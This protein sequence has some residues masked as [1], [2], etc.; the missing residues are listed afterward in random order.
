MS[1]EKNLAVDESI[2]RLLRKRGALNYIL[3]ETGFDIGKCISAACSEEGEDAIK[4]IALSLG[5]S[6]RPV[7]QGFLF[8]AYRVYRTIKSPET[9]KKIRERLGGNLSWG[10]LVHNCTKAPEGN[11]E[12]AALFLDRQM[13]RIEEAL[14]DLERLG[15]S[16]EDLPEDVKEQVTGML[17]AIQYPIPAGQEEPN[18][19][20]SGPLRIA[21]IG[22]I[23]MS[24]LF[25]T[26]G[27]LVLDPETGK[28]ERL[29]DIKRCL[30]FAIDKA[31][32]RGCRVLLVAGDVADRENPT[33][34]EQGALQSELVRAADYMPVVVIPGNHDLSKN[35][36]DASA[37]EFLK[38]RPN[39]FVLEKPAVLYLEGKKITVRNLPLDENFKPSE[40][41]GQADC[42]KIFCL[43]FP[44]KAL[45]NGEAK[46][47]SIAELNVVA[48]SKLKFFLEMFRNNFDK[49]V[50]NILVSHITVAGA[51][52]ATNE[53]MLMFDPNVSPFDLAGFDYVAL[54]HIHIFQ[55]VFPHAFYSGSLDTIG[56]DE[57]G[58]KKGF[59]IGEFDPAQK[60]DE[61]I[62]LKMEFIE[63]PARQF[64]TLTPEFFDQPDWKEMLDPRTIYRVKGEVTK[65][66]YEALKPHLREFPVPLLNKLTVKREMRI[67]DKGMTD[68]LSE[69]DAIKRYFMQLGIPE[70]Q[71]SAYLQVHN[72]LLKDEKEEKQLEPRIAGANQLSVPSTHTTFV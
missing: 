10:F 53:Q 63:T 22:D 57:E 5:Q 45:L 43:P 15:N 62:P 14:G 52:G 2:V 59:I 42:A 23:Q 9:L 44:S 69:T 4:R 31:I 71:L 17:A 1:E 72:D 41:W 11:T 20:L 34:N 65:E 26:A 21:H 24:E 40:R 36:K 28:N 33:P 18:P 47:K 55:E 29:M 25:T 48:S 39:I 56:F 50:P 49:Q 32:E 38:G 12:E 67:R 68:D 61:G 30:A 19:V 27:R 46:G 51:A 13:S 37:I 64:Q 54:G 35:P 8:D 16:F 70:D 6:G 3:A 66:R 7:H 58:Q 60:T